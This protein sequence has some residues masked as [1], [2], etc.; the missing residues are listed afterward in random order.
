M[1]LRSS[2]ILRSVPKKSER[3]NKNSRTISLTAAGWFNIGLNTLITA[4]DEWL[5]LDGSYALTGLGKARDAAELPQRRKAVRAAG[6]Y[7]MDV[8]LMPHVK[9]EAVARR[10]EHAVDGDGQ[11][12]HAE[13]RGEVPAGARDLRDK[14]AAQLV[15]K[16]RKLRAVERP[17]VFRRMNSV[18]DQRSIPLQLFS[19]GPAGAR[20]TAAMS[21]HGHYR[22]SCG[23]IQDIQRDIHRKIF[24]NDAKQGGVPKV[25]ALPGV[26]CSAFPCCARAR[27]GSPLLR[28]TD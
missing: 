6:E 23:N 24:V 10:V 18:Q 11:L 16:K 12:H 5:G 2:R 8:A 9:N 21:N 17:E 26:T 19:G 7:F 28:R 15:A 4:R 27:R 25:S 3:L 1:S 14:K 13:V 22:P 20:D